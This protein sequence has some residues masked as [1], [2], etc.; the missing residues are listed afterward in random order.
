MKQFLLILGALLFST[1]AFAGF[2]AFNGSTDLKIFN[3]IKCGSGMSCSKSNDKFLITV[4][5]IDAS[6]GQMTRFS[7]FKIGALSGA[8]TSITGS[9]TVAYVSQF[10]MPVNATLT[11]IAI[12][13]GATVGT[14]KYIVAIANSSGTILANSALAGTLSVGATAWQKIPFTATYAAAGPA[15]YWIVV[16]KNGTTDNFQAIPAA[17][18]YA[19]L[20]GSVTSQT[21]GTIAAL[22]LPTTFTA[23]L[24]PI[25]YTY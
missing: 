9:A 24:G 4:A 10:Y 2:E 19:G 12:L 8:G 3:K 15:V 11:G 13:N 23:D 14:D 6:G 5:G 1:T 21:F 20:A 16:Y 17:G 22:T 18:A 7:S 25:F